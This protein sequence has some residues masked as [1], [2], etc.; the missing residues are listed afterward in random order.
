MDDGDENAAK[1][2]PVASASLAE[3]LLL[4]RTELMVSVDAS[5]DRMSG[6]M[7]DMLS[8]YDSGVQTQLAAQQRQVSDISRRL[9]QIS[10]SSQEVVSS[11]YRLGVVLAAVE[12]GVPL[13]H[14]VLASFDRARCF[15][16]QVPVTA[17][18]GSRGGC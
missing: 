7:E 2:I 13:R 6:K 1:Q 18:S 9:D 12:S 14:P 10:Q 5:F 8:K 16:G 3:L 4:L 15:G 11:I 17:A